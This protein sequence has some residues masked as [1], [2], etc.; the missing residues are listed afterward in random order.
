[1]AT[2]NGYVSHY[3]KVV[4]FAYV[5]DSELESSGFPP[6]S[7]KAKPSRWKNSP[8]HWALL[9]TGGAMGCLIVV[10]RPWYD[11]MVI[12]RCIYIYHKLHAH[13]QIYIYIYTHLYLQKYID[14]DMSV[15]D[16]RACARAR[17]CF[18]FCPGPF[19][20]RTCILVPLY[21]GQEGHVS[22]SL[23]PPGS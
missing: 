6:A 23:L 13:T 7:L 16:V 18:D 3:Q 2:F 15:R 9:M 14:V 19:L 20:S 11:M 8:R 12:L 10:L 4:F 5:P 22:D 1:M 17:V 21:D